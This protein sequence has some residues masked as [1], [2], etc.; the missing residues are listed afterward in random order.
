MDAEATKLV[1]IVRLC[2][3]YAGT[4]NAIMDLTRV[5]WNAALRTSVIE[6]EAKSQHKVD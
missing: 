6:K 5:L 4:I 2:G 1:E 3:G